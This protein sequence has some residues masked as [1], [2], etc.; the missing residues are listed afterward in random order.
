MPCGPSA[1]TCSSLPATCACVRCP[2]FS[3]GTMPSLSPW[4]TRVGTVT[5]A[6]SPVKSSTQEPDA[7][8]GGVDVGLPRE[9]HRLLPLG[10]A[11]LQLAVGA[12]EVPRELVEEALGVRRQAGL[13]SLD[14]GVVE[15]AVGVLVVLLE[16]RRDGGREDGAVHPLLAV[17]ADVAGDLASAHRE[18]H[19]GGVA[20]VELA[21]H[22]VE[23]AREGVV[24]VRAVG[25]GLVGL[26]EA[27]TVVGH[28]AVA[29]RGEGRDL[30]RP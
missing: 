17:R 8:P 4:T 24:A 16:A 25:A 27:A 29:G 5:F 11:D 6:R 30:L 23:V 21:Q 12:E 22:R 9:P 26:P 15:R 2:D 14:G 19:E 20:Q 1:I 10:V 28:D 3:S 13:H 7:L 18:A